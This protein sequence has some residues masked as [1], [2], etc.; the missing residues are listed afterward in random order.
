MSSPTSRASNHRLHNRKA[1]PPL[2]RGA[3]GGAEPPCAAGG[4]DTKA[5]RGWHRCP[6]FF[7]G[8]FGKN[9]DG[10]GLPS[11]FGQGYLFL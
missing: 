2:A 9:I 10:P 6:F 3:V 1:L 11:V 8:C 4:E 5:A 7:G